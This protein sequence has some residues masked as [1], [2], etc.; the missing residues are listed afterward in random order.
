MGIIQKL[1]QVFVQQARSR[2]YLAEIAAG[3][4]ALIALA[5][6]DGRS[7]NSSERFA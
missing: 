2:Q 3:S 6:Y 5:V 4:D 7:R 1:K